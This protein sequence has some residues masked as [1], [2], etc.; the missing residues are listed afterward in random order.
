MWQRMI[1][2]S[3]G[4]LSPN[5]EKPYEDKK[6]IKPFK[7]LGLR[8]DLQFSLLLSSPFCCNIII[9]CKKGIC[10]GVTILLKVNSPVLIA[11]LD[12]ELKL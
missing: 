1:H 11:F 12:N 4:K 5:K 3:L 10:N 7:S 2:I 8:F 6:V 9:A